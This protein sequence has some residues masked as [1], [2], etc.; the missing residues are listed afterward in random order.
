MWTFCRNCRP[1][2]LFADTVLHDHLR[3]IKISRKHRDEATMRSEFIVPRKLLNCTQ[4]K[5]KKRSFSSMIDTSLSMTVSSAFPIFRA[6]VIGWNRRRVA[7]TESKIH[8]PVQLLILYRLPYTT[9]M[10]TE[11]LKI[12]LQIIRTYYM[13]DIKRREKEV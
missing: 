1:Y 10:K 6:I 7:A 4:I 13:I 2:I 11:S 9:M 12:Y 8:A 3:I 5:K